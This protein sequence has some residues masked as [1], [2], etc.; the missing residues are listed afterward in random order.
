MFQVHFHQLNN[1]LIII[2]TPYTVNIREAM[3]YNRDHFLTKTLNFVTLAELGIIVH[4]YNH[5]CC[6]RERLKLTLLV[7]TFTSVMITKEIFHSDYCCA[8]TH[9]NSYIN[10]SCTIS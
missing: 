1:I 6:L 4:Y 7:S 3:L 5:N 10:R 2:H 8:C 9:H